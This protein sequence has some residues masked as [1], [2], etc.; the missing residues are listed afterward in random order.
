MSN[1]TH[2]VPV[3][4]AGCFGVLRRGQGLVGDQSGPF[5]YETFS[6]A[7]QSAEAIAKTTGRRK[8]VIK[9]YPYEE[10]K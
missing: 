1:Q 4:L 5:T 7:L 3:T 2:L 6:K 9:H 10:I 8:A